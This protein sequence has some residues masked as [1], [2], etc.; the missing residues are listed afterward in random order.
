MIPGL[1]SVL[2]NQYEK[3]KVKIR[4][5]KED[6][7]VPTKGEWE[8]VLTSAGANKKAFTSSRQLSFNSN[9]LL[10]LDSNNNGVIEVSEALSAMI[11]M[12]IEN[13][14]SVMD[15]IADVNLSYSYFI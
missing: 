2:S 10:A 6:E 14:E 7:D 12:G 15:D 8:N 11:A 1:G 4:S 5:T 9:F 3:L 13:P